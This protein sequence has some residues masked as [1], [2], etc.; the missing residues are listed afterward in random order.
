MAI[1]VAINHKL[2][3]QYAKAVWL[4]PHVVRLR[5][6][7]HCRTPIISY[8][9]SVTPKEHFINWQQDPY[10]NYLARLVFPKQT[11]EFTAEVDL[12][13]ELTVFNPFDYFIEHYAQEFPF[14]YEEV[15]SRELEP[16]FKA[17][18]AGPKLQAFIAEARRQKTPTTAYLVELNQKVQQRIKYGI[19]M[20]AGV[21]EP[22]HTLTC[23][24][25]SCR[26]SS[27]LM[28]QVLRHLG[29]AARFVSGYLIQIAPDLPPLEG[30]GGPMK[31]IVDLHAWVEVY[32]PG[33]GWIGLDPTSG[34]MASEGHLP[35]ACTADP[36]MAAAIT[37][38]FSIGDQSVSSG[39]HV[40]NASEQNE[41]DVKEAKDEFHFSMSLTRISESPRVTKPYTEEQWTEIEEMGRQIDRDLARGDVRL[42]MG[43]EPTF[44]SIDNLEAEEWNTA[45]LGAHKYEI[46][47]QL[48]IRLRDRFAIGGFLHH[49]QGKWYPGEPLPRWA[50]G[51]YWRKDGKPIWRDPALVADEKNPSNATERDALIFATHLAGRLGV[52]PKHVQAGYEDV[53]W[54][55][56]KEQRLPVNVDPFD[57]KLANPQDRARLARI[58]EQGLDKV[59]G[60]CLPLKRRHHRDGTAAWISGPWFFRPERMYLV[61]GDSPM[62][63]RLPLDS[64]PWMA[65][66]DLPLMEGRDP[67]EQRA[68]LPDTAAY[69]RSYQP[70][71]AGERVERVMSAQIEQILDD[72]EESSDLAVA[73]YSAQQ[74]TGRAARYGDDSTADVGIGTGLSGRDFGERDDFAGRRRGGGVLPEYRPIFGQSARDTVRTALCTQVRDGVLRIFMPPLRYVEDYLELIGAIEETASEM[75]IPILVEGYTPP[76]DPRITEMKVTPDPGV[77]EVNTHPAAD[78]EELVR[79]TTVLDEEARQCRLRTEKFMTDG[80]HVGTGGGNHMVFG[81]ATPD[82]SPILRRPELLRSM[83][84][85]WHNH[86]SLSYVFSGMFVGPTSQ[87]PRVDE[88]RTDQVY[89]MEIAFRQ[90]PD[91]GQVAPWIV[92][93][94]FRNLL[95]DSTGNTHRAEFCIDKLYAPESATGRLGLLEMRGFEMPP[96]PRM[97]ITQALLIRAMIAWFWKHPYKRP[98]VRWRTEIHDRFL[99]PHFIR[100]DLADVIADLNDA[101][102]PI[103]P[104]WFTPH[105]EFRLPVLGTLERDGIVLELRQAIEPWHVLGESASNGSTVRFVDPSVERLQLMVNGMT[106]TRHRITCNGIAIPLYPTGTN[107]QFVAGVRYRAWHPVTCLHP[108]IGKHSPLVFDVLDTW[109]GRSVGGCQYHAVHPGGRN[110]EHVPVNS[111]EAEA[112]RNGRFYKFGHTGGPMKVIEVEPS[113]EFP[114]TLDLRRYL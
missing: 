64:I 45:A 58:F 110:Y 56:W 62:G 113:E 66:D 101:G 7:P 17:A 41:A 36:L 4:S 53:W 61:P 6:A 18:P 102:F 51:I 49:G 40:D 80:R 10:S 59:V 44:V 34:L 46:A 72:D 92:D 84:G 11:R 97:G 105:L 55:L 109:S 81:G 14:A 112:R 35:M 1:R 100:K 68:A 98:L 29:F 39:D 85:Y 24:S 71:V 74:S 67:W 90:I 86:P 75:K 37:G 26:D 5:P 78:W 33:A 94:I 52:N 82:D 32:L 13:A 19:R 77:I 57:S 25:G 104:E 63:F 54:H 91:H 28:I 31:D 15:L 21:Q 111:Y 60:Y 22:E 8:S 88:A 114:L 12:V 87:A 27:W 48:A 2:S 3:H 96:H 76:G 30:P 106:K 43:G 89:E 69:S 38:F 95:V 70:F 103:K 16:Y 83:L 20:E 23:L 93:R 79:I 107:G 9:L 50:L 73:E 42:T 108:T 99:L 65:P 47:N